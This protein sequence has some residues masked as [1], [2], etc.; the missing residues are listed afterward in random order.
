MFLSGWKRRGRREEKRKRN[1]KTV[2]LLEVNELFNGEGNDI[3]Y[4]QTEY[5]L[6]FHVVAREIEGKL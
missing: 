3:D 5:E 6:N 4:K 2:C 1:L